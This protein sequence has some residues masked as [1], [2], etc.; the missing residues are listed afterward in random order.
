MQMSTDE[1][2]TQF[3]SDV[4]DPLRGPAATPDADSLWKIVDTQYYLNAAASKV[5]RKTFALR[6]TFDLPVT[7]SDPFV[8]LPVNAPVLHVYRAYLNTARRGLD[9]RNLD[10]P[11]VRLD[12]GQLSRGDDSWA[13]ATGTPVVYNREYKAGYLRLLPVPTAADT[14]TLTAAYDAPRLVDGMPM[15]FVTYEDIDLVLL[16]MKYLAYSKKDVDTFDPQRAAANERDFNERAR[17][18]RY[19]VERE[20]RSPG[21]VRYSW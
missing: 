13:T 15:P 11:T 8:K 20:Y 9:E 18:R 1:V 16:W 10:E 3:R 17:E 19:E 7:A 2:I 12:Y 5:A 6:R 4:D 21:A 14:L